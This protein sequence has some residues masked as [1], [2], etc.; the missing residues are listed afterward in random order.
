MQ[1]NAV[2]DFQRIALAHDYP[3]GGLDTARGAE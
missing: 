1:V 2:R 3:G